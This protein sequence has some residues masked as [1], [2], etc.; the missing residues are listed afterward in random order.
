MKLTPTPAWHHI[1]AAL[2]LTALLTSPVAAQE[3]SNELGRLF[4][5]PE[6]RQILD[7]QRQQNIQQEQDTSADP[8]LTI[9]GI[10]TRSSG[11]R[12]AWVNDRPQ[13]ENEIQSEVVLIPNRKDPGRIIVQSSESPAAKAKVGDT[14][15]RNTG[16]STNLLEGGQIDIRPARPANPA[17]FR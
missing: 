16:E 13:H 9:N 10:V 6:R 8:S 5:T 4:F 17:P 3:A 2:T 11:K 14:V 15:N 12:T 1:L 7:R